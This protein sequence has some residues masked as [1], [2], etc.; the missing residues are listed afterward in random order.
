MSRASSAGSCAVHPSG[1]GIFELTIKP[2]P[3]MRTTSENNHRVVGVSERSLHISLNEPISFSSGMVGSSLGKV[4]LFCN[5]R[6]PVEEANKPNRMSK[7]LSQQPANLP[8]H[9]RLVP[10]HD[11]DSEGNDLRLKPPECCVFR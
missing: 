10:H 11:M 9:N 6:I 4:N 3:T 7:I 2:I 5:A 8:C 1:D